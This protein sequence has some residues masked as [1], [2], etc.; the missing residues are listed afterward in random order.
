MTRRLRETFSVLVDAETYLIVARVEHRQSAGGRRLE[1]MTRY[2]DYRPVR[3]VLVP[4]K[5]AV[6]TDGKLVQLTVIETVEANPA[7]TAEMF[8]RP[9]GEA[10]PK[11]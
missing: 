6:L 1:I 5:V 8:A 4:H 11:E 7:V 10:L 2:E 3:G 9:K